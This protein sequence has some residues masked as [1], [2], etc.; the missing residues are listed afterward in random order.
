MFLPSHEYTAKRSLYHYM[1]FYRLR[2]TI[3]RTHPPPHF[4]LP[5][6]T[7]H[8]ST[9]HLYRTTT[10]PLGEGYHPAARYGHPE[11]PDCT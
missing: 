8:P 9:P 1:I 5:P 10:A 11:V 4:L 7:H 3:L 6:Q 2:S